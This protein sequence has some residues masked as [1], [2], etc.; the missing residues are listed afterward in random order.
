MV[1]WASHGIKAAMTVDRFG[2]LAGRP[3]TCT[4]FVSDGAAAR[5]LFTR[6]GG[7]TDSVHKTTGGRVE[8]LARIWLDFQTNWIFN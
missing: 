6:C 2:M 1:G 8:G 5:G 4:S 3:F 7:V